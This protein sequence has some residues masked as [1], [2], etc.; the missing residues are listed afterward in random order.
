MCSKSCFVLVE[1]I[2]MLAQKF[3][4][5]FHLQIKQT[6]RYRS[7]FVICVRV[8]GVCMCVCVCWKNTMSVYFAYRHFNSY[9]ILPFFHWGQKNKSSYC[10]YRK[11]V[12][13]KRSYKHCWKN[14]FFLYSPPFFLSVCVGIGNLC[15]YIHN[16]I[17]L[18]LCQPTPITTLE[19]SLWVTRV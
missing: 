9:S 19:N 1:L 5:F 8:C 7:L 16:F 2:L 11:Y 18:S 13:R 17:W 14:V 4:C 10:E 3:W 15:K 12:R 6:I